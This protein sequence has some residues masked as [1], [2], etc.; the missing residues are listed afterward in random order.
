MNFIDIK[1][2]KIGK[3]NQDLEKL[4]VETSQ[5]KVMRVDRIKNKIPN[6]LKDKFSS[7]SSTRNSY[8]VDTHKSYYQKNFKF[9]DPDNYRI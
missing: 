5:R 4:L 2:K 1:M 6:I 7:S 8:E 9:L 3:D